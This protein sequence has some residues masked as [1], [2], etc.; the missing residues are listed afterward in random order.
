[1]ILDG[2][3]VVTTMRTPGNDI[4]MTCGW[5]INESDVFEPGDIATIKEFA[6]PMKLK[7]RDNSNMTVNTKRT[8]PKM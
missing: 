8:I 7:L 5:L 4:E 3:V 6:I 1:M 2:E